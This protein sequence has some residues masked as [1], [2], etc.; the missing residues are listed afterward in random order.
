MGGGGGGGGGGVATDEGSR[1]KPRDR[2]I[3]NAR[4]RL[5]SRVEWIDFSVIFKRVLFDSGVKFSRWTCSTPGLKKK[6]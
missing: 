3:S 5:M 6:E 4:F 1:L 2:L